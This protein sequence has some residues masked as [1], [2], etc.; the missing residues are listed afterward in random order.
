MSVVLNPYVESV[1]SKETMSRVWYI[2]NKAIQSANDIWINNYWTW[3][4]QYYMFRLEKT[5]IQTDEKTMFRLY[6]VMLGALLLHHKRYKCLFHIMTYTQTHPGSYPLTPSTLTEIVYFAEEFEALYSK[7]LEVEKRFPF[8]GVNE[9]VE[10]DAYIINMAYQYLSI[11][12]IRLWSYNDYNIRFCEPLQI[13]EPSYNDTDKNDNY[14]QIWKRFKEIIDKVYKDKLIEK[15]DFTKKPGQDDVIQKVEECI[16]ACEEKNAIIK[17]NPQ[18]DPNKIKNIYN[19]AIITNANINFDI[20]SAIQQAKENQ[21]IISKVVDFDMS[22]GV[23]YIRKGTVIECGNVGEALARG[24]DLK[25]RNAYINSLREHYHFVE[26]YVPQD[27]LT[28]ILENIPE[29]NVIIDLTSELPITPKRHMYKVGR[30]YKYDAILICAQE[31]LPSMS[32]L[33][34]DKDELAENDIMVDSFNN[35]YFSFVKKNTKYM[36]T[37]SQKVSVCLSNKTPKVEL[38]YIY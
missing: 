18:Y 10:T 4:Y 1:A 23:D 15:F 3:A 13:A 32:I 11:L 33:E 6:H 30:L 16:K 2:L 14:I 20:P 5:S 26:K 17:S 25:I 35:L 22:I 38:I 12:I 28:Q 27:E 37:L 24:L 31:D 8:I 21:R 19:D 7:P 29:G 36:L 9:G 34:K